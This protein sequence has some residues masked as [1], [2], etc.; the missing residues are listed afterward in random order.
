M[1][2]TEPS[3]AGANLMSIWYYNKNIAVDVLRQLKIHFHKNFEYSL[4]VNTKKDLIDYLASKLVIKH[5]VFIISSTDQKETAAIERLVRRRTQFRAFY[6]LKLEH[7]AASV[8]LEPISMYS[9][10]ERNFKTIIEDLKNT[11]PPLT[12]TDDETNN[13]ENVID[14]CRPAFDTLKTISAQRAFSDLSNESLKF[15][16]SQALIEVLVRM[17]YKESAFEHM[18]NLCHKDCLKDPTEANKIMSFKA[19]YTREKAINY[20]TQSSLFFRLINRAFRLEDVERIFHF[21]CYIADLHLELEKLGNRQRLTGIQYSKSFYRGKRYSTYVVQQ[22]V[23]NIG[24]LISINGFLS[25]TETFDISTVFAG[26]EESPGDYQSVVFEFNINRRMID[27]I[28][29]YANIEEVSSN[30]DENEVLF[31]MGF[32]WKIES[33]EEMRRN[34]WYI[35]LQSCEDYDA[36]L[37]TYIEQS[38]RDCTYLTLGNILRELGDYVNAKNFY[39]RMLRER[40]LSD[41][42]SW[43]CLF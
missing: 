2:R 15:F 27:F 28:R 7:Q 36:E 24:N 40:N 43:S 41:E 34:S 12:N 29:P 5:I 42:N 32:V 3:S 39:Q 13:E 8:L 11:E 21:G 17:P 26:I 35:V 9:M 10:I 1:V 18:W 25:T 23:D 37:V 22:L 19:K 6:E 30:P 31:F 4:I 38:R 14:D 33:M 20:Y 16:L